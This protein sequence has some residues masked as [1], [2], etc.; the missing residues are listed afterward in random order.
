MSGK[1]TTLGKAK[2]QIVLTELLDK[3]HWKIA[4]YIRSLHNDLGI[5]LNE[6]SRV[7]DKSIR[8]RMALL[9]YNDIRNKLRYVYVD[10]VVKNHC[11]ASFAAL[12]R[13]ALRRWK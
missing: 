12:Y 9:I 7:E 4:K 2:C 8:R 1:P 10:Q 13:N 6:L 11:L 5:A 3:V